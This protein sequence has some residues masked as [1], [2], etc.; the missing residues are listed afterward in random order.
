METMNFKIFIQTK[1]F[2]IA[3]PCAVESEA[4]LLATARGVKAAGAH[5][6]RGGA[7]KPRTSPHSFQGLGE[8]G[9]KLLA[10]ARAETGLPVVTEVLDTRDVLLVAEYADIIQIGSRS[11]QNFPLLK[12]VAKTKKPV[13]LKRGMAMTVEEWLSAADYILESGH[14]QI[15]LCERGIRTFE[16]ATRHTLDLNVVPLLKERTKLAVMVDPSHGTGRASLV[17]PM[18]KAALACGADGLLIEVHADPSHALSDGQ[19]SLDLPAFEKLMKTLLS[20]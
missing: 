4:Q 12:E 11:T 13:I 2:V 14:D 1:P 10:K 8:E 15:I 20:R 7:Y 16:T 6:L 19:Q 17:A 18:A 5:A 9:L 3:G